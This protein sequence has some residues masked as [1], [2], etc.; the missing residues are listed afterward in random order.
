MQA[1]YLREIERLQII[2]AK[3]DERKEKLKSEI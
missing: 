2:L 3:G 1:S